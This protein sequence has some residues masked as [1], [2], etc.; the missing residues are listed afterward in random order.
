MG[1]NSL[2]ICNERLRLRQKKATGAAS[3]IAQLLLLLQSDRV[4]CDL[5]ECGNGFGVRFKTALRNDQV[6]ELGRDIHIRQLE[7]AAR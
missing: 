3:K 1:Q 5:V 2:G 4:L 7:S 6:G